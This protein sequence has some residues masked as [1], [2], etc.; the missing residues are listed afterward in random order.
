[1]HTINTN[2]LIAVGLFA[3]VYLAFIARKT[4]RQQ[5]DLYDF[6]MLSMVALVPAAFVYWPGLAYWLAQAAG[7]AFPFV[8]MFG[9]LFLILFLFF[10]RMTVKMHRLERDNLLLIQEVS[11][12]RLE[13]VPGTTTIE[14]QE[15]HKAL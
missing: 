3:L 15:K 14:Q 13:L 7:V 11:L 10:Y 2:T 8:I 6:V 4:A 9:A 12:L 5:L 1:M